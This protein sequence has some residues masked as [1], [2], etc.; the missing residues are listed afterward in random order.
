MSYVKEMKDY[1]KLSS[2]DL[3]ADSIKALRANAMIGLL[4]V[5]IA[6]LMIWSVIPLNLFTGATLALGLIFVFLACL[7]RL[8]NLLS[9][10]EHHL[11]EWGRNAKKD[12]EAFTYRVV[13]YVFGLLFIVG[14][15][16]LASDV[17][18]LNLVLTPTFEQLG[19]TL[20]LL[21]PLL[22]MI[23]T[24]RLA[25]SV[26]PLSKEDVMEMYVVE[27]PRKQGKWMT[28]V[29]MIILGAGI[30]GGKLLDYKYADNAVVSP[31]NCAISITEDAP[32]AQVKPLYYC[33]NDKS[34]TDD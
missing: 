12:A 10:S 17:S 7:H 20:F 32:L 8:P 34:L 1:Y 3:S 4:A 11:D 30:F 21:M 28:V 33:A 29:M 23:K 13:Y 31:Q 2:K 5:I 27:K 18:G 14:T 15:A 22:V 9:V 19:G 6:L 26:R 25:W 24:N 16:F